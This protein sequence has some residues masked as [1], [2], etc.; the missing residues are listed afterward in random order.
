MPPHK[1][2]FC[3]T[4]GPCTLRAGRIDAGRAGCA[5]QRCGRRRR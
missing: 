3:C 2:H 4:S 5:A 1:G